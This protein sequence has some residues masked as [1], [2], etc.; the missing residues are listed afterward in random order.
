VLNDS[1]SLKGKE[2]DFSF[3]RNRKMATAL[4]SSRHTPLHAAHRVLIVSPVF[5]PGLVHGG[6][7]AITF[8]ALTRRLLQRGAD[9]QVLTPPLEIGRAHV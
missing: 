5:P 7:V 1:T 4:S 2:N 9:V 3:L 8:D 6:G